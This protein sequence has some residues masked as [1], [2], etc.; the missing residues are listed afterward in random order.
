M[1]DWAFVNMALALHIKRE[2]LEL[3]DCMFLR[4]LKLLN[5]DKYIVE[6][7]HS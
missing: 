2:L 6:E 7:Q 4:A 1:R 5:L 3:G